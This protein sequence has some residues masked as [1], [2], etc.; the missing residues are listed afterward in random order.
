LQLPFILHG[1]NVVADSTF[2]IKYLE[3]TY[4]EVVPDFTPEEEALSVAVQHFVD[5]F[6][7]S[8]L[9]WHRWIH[10]KVRTS[11]QALPD[12]PGANLLCLQA[13]LQNGICRYWEGMRTAD[14]DTGRAVGGAW[15]CC[16]VA[17]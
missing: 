1:K 8:G 16:C 14:C 15:P 9:V 12:G 13:Q 2:I 10:P 4:P 17:F 6:L 3:R 5:N 7:V 11:S